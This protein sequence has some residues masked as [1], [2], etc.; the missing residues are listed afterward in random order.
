MNCIFVVVVYSHVDAV[1]FYATADTAKSNLISI[2]AERN[3][4]VSD[5]ENV[6]VNV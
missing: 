6:P 2:V 5:S 1:Y 4:F 3:Y